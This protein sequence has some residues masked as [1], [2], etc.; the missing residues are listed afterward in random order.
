MP[1]PDRYAVIG[2]PIAHSRS[3]Q[4]H[5][6]FARQTHQS[7]TYTA[8][9]VTP[10]ELAVRVREFF[11]TGGSGLN[12][13]VPHK[14]AVIALT[15]SLSARA[16][17]AGAAN[18]I[19]RDAAGNLIAD[20]TDGAGLVRDLTHNLHIGVRAQRVLLVG[21]GG[22]ARG[23]LAPLLELGPRELVIANRGVERALALASAFAALGPVRGA[24]FG[25]L[26]RSCFDL[27]IN[28]TAAGLQ[29]Q[30]PLL[31]PGVIGPT[32][33]CYDLIYAGGDTHF[34][35]WA[36]QHGAAQAH[37]GLGMLVEQAAESFYLWRGVRP[38]TTPVLAALAAEPT[39]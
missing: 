8:L 4:I 30:V 1:A 18:T 2:H 12:V 33:I 27:I 23:V 28:A 6:L 24:G 26:D 11:A 14:E 32:T 9:D 20:N 31:P 21:A 35:R 16:C 25:E 29:A 39:H 5:A 19:L 15:A 3:P 38:D 37:M 36:R 34:M 7:M 13:T 10:E 17:T 22:A